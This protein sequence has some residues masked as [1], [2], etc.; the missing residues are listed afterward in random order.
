MSATTSTT[1]APVGAAAVPA[2]RHGRGRGRIRRH[3]PLTPYLL[4]APYLMLFIMFVAV[5]AVYGFW[6]SLHE[7][8]FM[9]PN[10]PFVGMQNYA[11]LFDP[12]SVN[13]PGF[14]NG[15]RATAIFT[16]VSVPFLVVVPLGVALLLNRQFRGRA[17]FRAMIFAPYVLGIAVVGLLFRYLLDS[18]FGLINWFIG[19]FGAPQIGWTQ[20]Q[21][22]AWIG[23]VVMTVW[24]TQ[25]FNAIIF[26]A[27]LQ[28]IA[29]DQYEAAAVDGAG[30]WDQ[31]LYVT[32]PNLRNILVFII[33][34]SILASANMF[35]QAYLV[36]NGGPG[37]ST[38]TVIMEMTQKG[39]R[40]FNM[41][42]ATAMSYVLA[43]VLAIVAVINFW[44]TRERNVT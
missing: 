15:M 29:A 17:F 1:A 13:G 14:W 24:W 36:T 8:D 23:L 9:L 42:S 39:L 10:K 19:L 31:F 5:P 26:L 16:V 34:I 7:W 40:D 32:I 12:D 28:G 37:D 35:G 33:T 21:P 22:W 6:V 30:K 18:Q 20:T 27:A 25:G 11:D 44:A 38:R 43:V 2:R 3:H 4:L 41:G